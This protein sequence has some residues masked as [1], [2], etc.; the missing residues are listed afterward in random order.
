MNPKKTKNSQPV[1]FE[2]DT[3]TALVQHDA[4]G[5][6]RPAWPKDSTVTAVFSDCKRY[7]YQILEVWDTGSQI[8][9]WILM[10]NRV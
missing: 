5:K 3:P 7:L 1:L 6:A 8:V 4:G 10:N 2:M 9:I